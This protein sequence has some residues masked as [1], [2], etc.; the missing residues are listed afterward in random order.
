MVELLEEIQQILVA[1]LGVKPEIVK[2]ESRL[3]EDLGADSMDAL[4][5]VAAL[6]EKFDVKIS[7]DE[8]K[9]IATVSS[10]V[11]LIEQK[12]QAKSSSRP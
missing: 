1:Q 3:V 11:S 12:L 6:E 5:L 10:I 9:R 8:A 7:D 2:S 4:E